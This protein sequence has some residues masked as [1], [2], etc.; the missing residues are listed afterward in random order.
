MGAMRSNLAQTDLSRQ[1]L[2]KEKGLHP[3]T[4]QGYRSALSNHMHGK[5]QWD[6]AR[7]PSLNRL[8]E[9]FFRDKPVIDRPIPLWNL[10][11]VLQS[12]TKAPFE[13][14]ALAPLKFVYHL[15]SHYS[16]W[17]ALK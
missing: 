7:Y 6:I 8:I 14:L 1:V 11:V 4:I 17:E 2:F 15:L 12:L 16:I 3:V 9:S 5:V 10:Q 13:P